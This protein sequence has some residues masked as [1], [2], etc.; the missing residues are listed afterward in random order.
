MAKS[1]V[2]PGRSMLPL[3]LSSLNTSVDHVN[4]FVYEGFLNTAVCSNLHQRE[5]CIKVSKKLK[6]ILL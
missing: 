6:V 5:V 3:W 4:L 2:L 1:A